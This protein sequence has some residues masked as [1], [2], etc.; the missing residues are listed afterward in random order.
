MR[1]GL[2]ERQNQLV[3]RIGARSA[4]VMFWISA[5]V[6][7]AELIWLGNFRVVVGETIIFL[8]G[9]LTCLAGC[10]KDGIWEKEG[11]NM[12]A[13]HSILLSV[14]CS[15]V[16]SIFYAFAISRKVGEDVNVTKYVA[17]FFIGISLICFVILQIMGK[18]ARVNRRRQ[19][20]KYLE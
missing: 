4:Y 14:I 12:S 2:D 10:L 15:G 5:A 19:E 6:I 17:A 7:V 20:D 8:V 9:G 13:G 1:R 18:I 11:S 16:F 3:D